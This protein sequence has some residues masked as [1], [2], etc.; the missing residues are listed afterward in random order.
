[1]KKEVFSFA[2]ETITA[3]DN[4][5][6]THPLDYP[7][8]LGSFTAL[9]RITER[10]VGPSVHLFSRVFEEAELPRKV[11]QGNALGWFAFHRFT[12]RTGIPTSQILFCTEG[13]EPALCRERKITCFVGTKLSVLDSLVSVERR[14]LF[15]PCGGVR[16]RLKQHPGIE[17]TASWGEFTRLVGLPEEAEDNGVSK[18]ATSSPSV[19]VEYVTSPVP[20]VV[21]G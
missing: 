7:E 12:E 8:V 3:S 15:F 4:P 14:F 2:A 20:S 9:R 17:M 18:P 13:G 11:E 10:F 5:L 16:P 6:H 19:E 1:M 21:C